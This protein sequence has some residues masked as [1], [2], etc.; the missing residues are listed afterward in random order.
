M[1]RY[2]RIVCYSLLGVIVFLNVFTA[3]SSPY[4]EEDENIKGILRLWNIDTFEGGTGSR[5]AF[6]SDAA[7][8]FEKKYKGLYITVTSMSK[9]SAYYSLSQGNI[10]DMISF[11]VGCNFSAYLKKLPF[12]F[13]GGEINGETYAYPWCRGGY[14]LF[15]LTED[16]SAVNGDNLIISEGGDNVPQISALSFGLNG[17]YKGA[18]SVPCY[19]DF[20]NGK[21]KYMLGT[22]RDI[23]RFKARD[24]EV[25]YESLQ[26]YNDL[27]QYI[28]VCSGDKNI[29]AAC[30]DFVYMLTDESVQKNL[31][32]IGMCS[33]YY[34]IYEKS[35]G[36]LY[37]ASVAK[38]QYTC[39]VF[40]FGDGLKKLREESVEA[41]KS[42]EIKKIK[43]YLK[44]VA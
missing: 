10:P 40:T 3:R 44:T 21:Y 19:I 36:A 16:F 29:Y 28:A 20:L 42:G 17:S 33:P 37:A 25:Y 12:S 27:Y 26:G 34:N 9:E 31:K 43:S 15:S 2:F 39:S 13:S 5:S 14:F 22:Q 1:N 30:L 32:K 23:Y 24:K 35:D 7:N 4:K 8:S 41:L 11:G 6:L 18:E 38:A